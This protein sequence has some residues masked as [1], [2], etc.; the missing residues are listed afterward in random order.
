MQ[1]AI[2]STISR[3]R[4]NEIRFF[5]KKATLNSADLIESNSIETCWKDL[6]FRPFA[7]AMRKEQKS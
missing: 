5:A 7:R 4:F 3:A 6:D 2:A 1:E